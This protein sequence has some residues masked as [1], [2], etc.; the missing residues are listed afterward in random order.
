MKSPR[1]LFPWQVTEGLRNNIVTAMDESDTINA[2]VA[3]I[4][5]VVPM[6]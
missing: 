2:L 6:N 5:R 4:T 1:S 3:G